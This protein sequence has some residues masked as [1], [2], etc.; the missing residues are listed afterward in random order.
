MKNARRPLPARRRRRTPLWA[1][2][3]AAAAVALAV[4]VRVLIRAE[5]ND[6][7]TSAVRY[8]HRVVNVYP[9]DPEAFTQGLIF[10][11]GFLFESTGLNGRSSLRKVRLETGEVVQRLAIDAQHF[12]EGLTDWDG[13]LIQL[14]WQSQIGFVYDLSTFA[15]R[16][17]FH[18]PGEGWGL[19]HDTSRIVMSDGTSVL[20]FLDPVSLKELGRLAVTDGGRPVSDL[21]E[22]EFI[23]GEIFANVW[24]GDEI[25]AIS[26]RTGTVTKRVNL[27]GLLPASDRTPPVDV[28]N[29]IAYDAA[30]DRLFV[31]GKQWP[32]LFEI[33]LSPSS[34]P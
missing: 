32:K 33:R 8:D 1:I 14:T 5:R 4:F 16:R 9:H 34:P 26:P 19:T 20:R 22:L 29:G 23:K 2:G 13:Q 24:P 7:G 27:S 3:L 31:T 18:Y 30:R 28:L 11:D 25:V 17:T 10:K 6:G 12:A 21:N 15:L